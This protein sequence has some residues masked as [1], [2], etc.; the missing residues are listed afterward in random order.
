[1]K[2]F[3]QNSSPTGVKRGWKGC[4]EIIHFSSYKYENFILER[5]LE[6]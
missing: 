6:I 4:M 3:F 1:M 2:G 5:Q